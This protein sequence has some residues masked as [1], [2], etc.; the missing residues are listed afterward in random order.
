MSK[1]FL[2]SD[3]IFILML[4]TYD[5]FGKAVY[6]LIANC[7]IAA[8]LFFNLTYQAFEAFACCGRASGGFKDRRPSSDTVYGDIVDAEEPGYMAEHAVQDAAS[9]GR[10][11]KPASVKR[12]SDRI[13]G[14]EVIGRNGE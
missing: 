4:T 13:D 9:G 5:Y 2:A 6:V 14:F 12:D 10:F 8:V 11:G 1:F 3:A 7:M